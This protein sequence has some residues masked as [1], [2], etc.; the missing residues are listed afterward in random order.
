MESVTLSLIFGSVLLI[1]GIYGTVIA[2]RFYILLD[3]PADKFALQV[4]VAFIFFGVLGGGAVVGSAFFEGTWWPFI[5]LFTMSGFLILAFS[6]L[7][8][9]RLLYEEFGSKVNSREERKHI[10]VGGF[11]IESLEGIK[12]LLKYLFSKSG[13][14]FVISRRPQDEWEEEF[15]IKPTKYLWLSRV[16]EKHSVSPSNL[17]VILEEA[18]KFMRIRRNSVIYIEGIEYLMLYNDFR[19]VAKFLFTLK[20]YATVEKSVLLIFISPGVLEKSH[21]NILR[22]ELEVLDP[23]KFLEEIMGTAL[24]GAVA[25]EDFEKITTEKPL[26]EKEDREEHASSESSKA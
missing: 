9:L 16:E 21:Y 2:W 8:Y 13:G 26:N 11:I 20:D 23:E 5:A 10:P 19:S 24:F 22:R 14:L 3:S 25:K 6:S 17:H 4:M 15:G 7:H 18:V 12:T 1:I